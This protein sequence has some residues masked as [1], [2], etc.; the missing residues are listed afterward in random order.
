MVEWTFSQQ[1]DFVI[2]DASQ[3]VSAPHFPLNRAPDEHYAILYP[4]CMFT[5]LT[6][7]ALPVFGSM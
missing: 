5:H 7:K 3:K 2:C 4:T 1:S 6:L